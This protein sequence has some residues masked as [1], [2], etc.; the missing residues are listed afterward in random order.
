MGNSGLSVSFAAGIVCLAI[1]TASAQGLE[2]EAPPAADRLGAVEGVVRLAGD[3]VALPTLIENSTDPDL[4]GK[5]HSLEDL[6]VSQT[7]RGVRHV[8]IALTDVPRSAVPPRDR[9]EL[10]L[11]NRDCRFVPHAS[12]VRVGDVIRAT[13][14]DTVAHNAHYYG[15]IE[16]NLALP[17]KGTSVSHTARRAGTIVVKCDIHGWMQAFIRVDDHPFHAV[18][19]P[20]GRFRIANLPE[21]VYTMELW[22][23]RLG[24][25]SRKVRIEPGKTATIEVEYLLDR[26]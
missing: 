1:L 15:R 7:S 11:D 23:E 6:V 25:L 4:C 2:P 13:N 10:V 24:T 19:D 5:T 16:A 21:G 3:A 17:T 20:E 22:H 9:A 26:P 8:I 14:S 12:V 18:T